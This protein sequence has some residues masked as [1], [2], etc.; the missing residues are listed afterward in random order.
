MQNKFYI[1]F[2]LLFL[3][4]T[5]FA[6][7]ILTDY[8]LNGIVN[9]EKHMDRELSKTDYWNEY[10][11]DKD[12]TF[13]YIESYS[14]ILA[15]NKNKST[16]AMYKKNKN[17]K[18]KLHKKYSA[19]TGKNKG[20]KHREGDLKTPIG[21]Y[22][23]TK[24]LSKIDS[25]YGPLAF[26]TSYPNTYDKY[27]DR[28]GHGIW[29]HG[30]PTDQQRDEFTK[31][32][33][34]INN[35]DLEDLDE[36]IDINKTLLIISSQDIKTNI[37]KK[38]L[39]I[40]LANL[41]GWRYAWKYSDIESYLQFYS[42]KFKRFDGKNYNSFTHYKTRIFRKKE[43]KKIIFD[44]INILPYPGASELYKISFKEY[45]KSNSFQFTGNKVLIVELK[46]RQIKILTEK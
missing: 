21:I 41:Y 44:N 7:N 11:Q 8:R 24:K 42:T 30:L 4:Q 46:N 31:G 13:G 35:D 27:E 6:N 29:I 40:L 14:N 12:T 36:N 22:K 19:F 17:K 2:A 25:F 39:S 43:K 10:L 23:I 26:V 15:C 20:E 3:Q 16:L 32:C 1:I 34:A 18:Y 5:L 37:S 33:I 28:E 45:Y 38:K 9:I